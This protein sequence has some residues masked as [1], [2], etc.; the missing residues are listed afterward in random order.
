MREKKGIGENFC[1]LIYRKALAPAGIFRFERARE[2]ARELLRLAAA[3]H[4]I[5]ILNYCIL[6]GEMMILADASSEKIASLGRSLFGPVSKMHNIRKHHEGS[7]WKGRPHIALI[8]K[9]GFLSASL[10]AVDMLPVARKFVRHPSEWR[11]SGFQELAGIRERY[12]IIDGN[13]ICRLSGFKNYTDFSRQHLSQVESLLG[14]DV[15]NC[16]PFDALAVGDDEKTGLLAN[17]L[18]HKF[19]KIRRCKINGGIDASALFVSRSRGQSVLRY[20]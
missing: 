2:E 11:C 19:R 4:E 14:S 20:I 3:R 12:R 7:C 10:S 17:L 8:Q 15:V 9:D 5:S 13:E 1:R 6:P 16:F 18:P